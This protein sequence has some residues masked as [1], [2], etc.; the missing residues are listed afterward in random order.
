MWKPDREE[1]RYQDDPLDKPPMPQD[2]VGIWSQVILTLL[3]LGLIVVLA[4]FVRG[5]G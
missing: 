1:S 4:I 5:S 2:Q 3:W